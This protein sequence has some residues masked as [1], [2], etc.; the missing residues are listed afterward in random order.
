VKPTAFKYIDRGR[1]NLSVLIPGWAT[2]YRIFDRLNLNY[3]YLIPVSFSPFDF[4]RSLLKALKKNNIE[5]IS[6]FGWSLGGFIAAEFA[7]RYA[8]FIDELIL[9]SIRRKYEQQELAQIKRHLMRNK[10]GYLYKF[11]TRCFYKREKIPWFR[12]NFFRYYCQ[13][14]DLDYLLR[15]LDYL[16]NAQINPASLNTVKRIKIIHGEHD[17]IAPIQEAIDIKEGLAYAKFICIKDAGHA[18]FFKKGFA[19]YI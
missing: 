9:V 19:K 17:S 1:Q 3:N 11:Y 8:D 13:K 15:T 6:L 14:L 5:K 16:K 10:K 2:D 4:E 18:P 12:K 7:S